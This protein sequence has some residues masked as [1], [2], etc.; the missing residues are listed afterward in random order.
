MGQKFHVQAISRPGHDG[1]WR[2]GRK[3]PSGAPTV[4]EV[5]DDPQDPPHDP[6]KGVR[7][8]RQTYE[9]IKADRHLTIRAPGDPLEHAQTHEALM[10]ENAR[11]KEELARLKG[12]EGG[13]T[14]P[15]G[16]GGEGALTEGE[17]KSKRR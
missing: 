4:V 6:A 12:G 14:E 10:A 2:A 9:A 16:H 7:I 17:A 13:K 1:A 3:W 5:V 15:H 11:M 8:G